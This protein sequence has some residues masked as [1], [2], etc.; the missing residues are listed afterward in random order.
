MWPRCGR[1]VAE[2]QRGRGE[3][4]GAAKRTG[5]PR[6]A[7]LVKRGAEGAAAVAGEREGILAH[8]QRVRAVDEGEEHVHGDEDASA[9][10]EEGNE[11]G[12]GGGMSH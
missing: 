9:L 11:E 1:D 3:R 2:I 10:Q 6:A 12:R 7:E 4:R 5:Q 8:L